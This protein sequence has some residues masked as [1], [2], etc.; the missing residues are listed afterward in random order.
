MPDD[1]FIWL[2]FLSLVSII[3][4]NSHV[5]LLVILIS[6]VKIIVHIKLENI[7]EHRKNSLN[8]FYKVD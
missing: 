2:V 1:A 5:E 3:S 4:L 6:I 7:E 8:C